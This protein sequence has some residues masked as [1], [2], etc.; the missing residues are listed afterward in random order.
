MWHIRAERCWRFKEEES[1][2]AVAVA[3]EFLTDVDMVFRG[4]FG[5]PPRCRLEGD[6]IAAWTSSP[7]FGYWPVS[8]VDEAH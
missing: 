8:M 3:K 5:K 7:A 2:P 4:K 6:S 1:R